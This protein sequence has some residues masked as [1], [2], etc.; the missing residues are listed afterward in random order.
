ML[1]KYTQDGTDAMEMSFKGKF[2]QDKA[3]SGVD[4]GSNSN[5]RK[6][7]PQLWTAK[8]MTEI[9]NQRVGEKLEFEI[10]KKIEN[11]DLVVTNFD[12]DWIAQKSDV[13]DNVEAILAMLEE[14]D[15]VVF[16]GG[17]ILGRYYDLLIPSKG[18]DINEFVEYTKDPIEE[19]MNFRH[20][21]MLFVKKP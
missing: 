4:V 15:V 12:M 2:R 17:C 19:L 3:V 8:E 21:K 5:P 11:E 7:D 9:S 6:R 16:Y 10:V 20:P 1:F 13:E 18:K 14:K